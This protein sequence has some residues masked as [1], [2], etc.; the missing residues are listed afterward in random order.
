MIDLHSPP[1]YIEIA[2]T[3]TPGPPLQLVPSENQPPSPP[4]PAPAQSEPQQPQSSSQPPQI[5]V[6]PL[7]VG[8]YLPHT[9]LFATIVVTVVPPTGTVEIYTPGFEGSPAVFKGP[10]TSGEIRLNGP[11]VYVHLENGATGYDVEYLSWREP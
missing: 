10:K 9:A 5:D 2:Q 6:T 8:R 7:D 4:P 1:V 3:Q 11:T